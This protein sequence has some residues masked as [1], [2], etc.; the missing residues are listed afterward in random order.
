MMAF[1]VLTPYYSEEVV[2]TKE[3]L[4]T[5][6]ED[7]VSILYYLQTIYDDEWKNFVERMRRE[8]M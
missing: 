6:N 5:E 2:Y 3:Q 4:R 8:G 1:S 7:G